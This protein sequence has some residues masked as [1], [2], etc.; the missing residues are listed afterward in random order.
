MFVF[1]NCY[2]D[3]KKK[4]KNLHN[5]FLLLPLR[6][7]NKIDIFTKHFIYL[8]LKQSM[9]KLFFAMIAFALCMGMTSCKDSAKKDGAD[10]TKTEAAADNKDGEKKDDAKKDEAKADAPAVDASNIEATL[11]DL[12]AKAKAD[13][14]NW[15]VDDWKAQFKA[16]MVACKPMLVQLKEIQDKIQADPSKA[17]EIMKDAKDLEAQYTKL[18]SLMEEFSEVAEKTENGKK[19]SEDEAFQKSVMEELGLGDLDM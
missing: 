16:A 14:A 5:H 12:I 1:N 2:Y 18:G 19:A 7:Q 9:K 11:T 8:N 15:S 13:G 3:N 10:S 6:R 17:K 4:K